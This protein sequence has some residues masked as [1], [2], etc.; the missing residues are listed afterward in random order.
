M[1]QDSRENPGDGSCL[2]PSPE[3]LSAS[4]DG[5]L[6]LS[7]AEKTHV[8]ECPECRAFLKS[9]EQLRDALEY[10]AFAD[11]EAVKIGHRILSRVRR[12]ILLEKRKRTRVFW[13]IRWAALGLMGLFF[14][15]LIF[16]CR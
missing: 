2:C 15:Y 3:T 12:G 10:N 16:R 9:C 1:Q 5:E 6:Q 14:L 13:I 7:E 11:P 8:R 4:F